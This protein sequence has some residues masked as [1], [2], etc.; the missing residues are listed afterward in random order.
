MSKISEFADKQRAHNQAISEAI[1][2]I[3][4]DIGLL[5]DKINELQNT[6]GQITPE[7]QTLLDEME[8]QG[9]ALAERVKSVDDLTPPVVPNA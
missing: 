1:D 7:D 5:N 3:T 9:A 6:Q 2:G 4:T 8:A